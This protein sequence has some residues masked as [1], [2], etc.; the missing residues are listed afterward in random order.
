M[1][2]G[3]VKPLRSMENARGTDVKRLSNAMFLCELN[4]GR[5]SVSTMII[6]LRNEVQTGSN[7]LNFLRYTLIQLPSADSELMQAHHLD[8]WSNDVSVCCD[9]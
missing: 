5:E 1:M 7:A 6:V 9:L 8:L 2:P 4:K 3:V